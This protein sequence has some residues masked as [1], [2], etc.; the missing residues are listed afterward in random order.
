MS[1]GHT[2]INLFSA[3][4]CRNQSLKLF[5]TFNT[6]DLCLH[7][8]QQKRYAVVAQLVEHWLPKPRAAGSSPVYRSKFQSTDYKQIKLNQ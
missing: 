6:A 3:G 2:N 4:C 8:C 7:L 5:L 1:L